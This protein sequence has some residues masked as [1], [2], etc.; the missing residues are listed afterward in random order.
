L[1]TTLKKIEILA[2]DLFNF[3]HEKILKKFLLK[4]K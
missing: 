1:L 2:L 4:F 3:F